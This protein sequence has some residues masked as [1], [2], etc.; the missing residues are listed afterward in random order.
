MP[1]RTVASAALLAGAAVLS[2]MLVSSRM[3]PTSF[4]LLVRE[5]AW[6]RALRAECDGHLSL[7]PGG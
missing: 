7:T 2:V 3:L 5:C 1:Q 4:P 6:L